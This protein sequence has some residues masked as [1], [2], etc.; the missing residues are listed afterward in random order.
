MN[1]TDRDIEHKLGGHGANEKKSKRK[2]AACKKKMRDCAECHFKLESDVKNFLPVCFQPLL[3]CFC[4]GWKYFITSLIVE[5]ILLPIACLLG[6]VTC[7]FRCLRC[8]HGQD[9]L[10]SFL[11]CFE[12][13]E[14]IVNFYGDVRWWRQKT[15]QQVDIVNV[16]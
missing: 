9:C 13:V 8:P 5:P 6:W 10:Y 3:S 14:A 12:H 1:S 11:E 7:F 16:V 15:E 4:L 2:T